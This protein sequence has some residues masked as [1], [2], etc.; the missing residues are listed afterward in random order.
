MPLQ[1]APKIM[2]RILTCL[3]TQHDW[4][5]VVI[6][7]AVGFVASVIAVRL[8]DRALVTTGR[9]CA[10]SII[11]AGTATGL[12]IWATHFIAML[13]YEPGIPIAYNIGL[14]ILSLVAAAVF[15]SLGFGIA[16][17]RP[18]H[19]GALIGGGIV[20]AG[21][22]SMHYL[23]MSALEL[24]G[25][26][27]WSLD[28]VFASVIL[29]ML[30]C[31]AA[32]AV[33]VRHRGSRSTLF[34]AL[35][36]TSAIV[37]HHFTAMGAVE[38]VPDPTRVIT[39]LSLS[40]IMLAVAVA[41][42]AIAVLGLN[43]VGTLA[44]RPLRKNLDL[45]TTTLNN[46]TQGVVMFDSEE[47]LVV[48]ND[49]YI[50]MYGLS[51]EIAKP[52]CTLS[53]LIN[54]RIAI[55]NFDHDP[56]QYRAEILAAIAKGK[57]QNW[58]AEN[59]DGRFISVINRPIAGG[60]WIGTH[61]DIT[62]RRRAERQSV[63]LAE[64]E[65]RR[66]FIDAAIQSF[67]ESVETVLRTVSDSVAASRTTATTLLSSAAET[68]QSAS[69]AIKTSNEASANILAAAS[70]A[71]ELLNSIA[72]ISR[73]LGKTT[74]LAGIA[75]AEA[76]KTNDE[77]A[78]LSRAAHEIGEVVDLI[79]NI[80]GQTNL[81]ALNATI[82]A[83]RAGESG[84]GFAV[85]ASEVKSLAVQ[86][87]KA[88]EKIAGQIAAVQRST[89]GAVTAIR[90]N[91]E[92]LQEINRYTMAVSSALDQQNA[93]TGEISQNVAGAAQ[94]AKA[95]VAVLED[96]SGAI[97]K[98]RNSAQTVLGASEAVEAAADNLREKV[99]TFL[100]RVAV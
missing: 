59:N 99:E 91:T 37:S 13:A 86:T 14:T 52:G 74:E 22:A 28:L 100:G 88:T 65:A 24:P 36:L 79:R 89:A 78:G 57:T 15:T 94:G 67:R 68:S 58:I 39:Q 41:G 3:S 71:E 72:E 70:A 73:Q 55:G 30:F 5:L 33:A 63:T 35:L 97:T 17:Y 62:E 66:A 19:L 81:L 21:I 54:S 60:F 29:G 64:Q 75:V 56:A 90:R 95:V 23:G 47:R 7:I 77:I 69:D 25:R 6:A 87:A 44:D 8:F 26:V 12:G 46:M 76:G 34:V 83:A 31:A 85:V 61:E 49:R 38:I 4:H 82:E 50:E 80:A 1:V 2:F 48:C 43:L 27:T 93:A 92:H 51:P 98:T 40:P 18:A 96:V 45:L 16:A 84:K 10:A 53:D 42:A 32:L 11:A 9:V 20:G